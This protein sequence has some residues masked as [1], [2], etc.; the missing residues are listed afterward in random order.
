MLRECSSAALLT[1]VFCGLCGLQ[2][3]TFYKSIDTKR[4]SEGLAH[5]IKSMVTPDP[6]KRP[7]AE[8]LLQTDVM[9]KALK[10][11]SERKRKQFEDLNENENAVSKELSR[12]V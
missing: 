6:K 3:N 9:Q 2:H 12:S 1:P 10:D 8:A 4:Y 7:S 5:L 11:A